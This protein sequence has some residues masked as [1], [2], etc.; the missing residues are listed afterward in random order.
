MEATSLPSHPRAL[1]PRSR[2]LL[3][4]L[5]DGRLV[6]QVRAGND[7]AFEVVYDRHH[8]GVL[9]FC[10]HMLG[11]QE[12]A[13]DA[14]QQTFISAYD[15]LRRTNRA[16][17][18]RPWLFTIARNRCLSVL[19][20]RRE[21]ATAEVELSTAGLA[22]DVERR[23]ELRELLADMAELP[24]EQRGA[25]VLSELGDLSHA[26]IAQVLG[27]EAAKVKSLVFQARS[28][29]IES[30]R[31]RETPCDEIRQQLATL[32]GGALRRGT[33][34][35]HVKACPGCSEYRDDVRRQRAMMAAVLPVIPSVGLRDGA[36]AAVGLG[37]GGSGGAAA[38]GGLGA[39]L[40]SGAA[41]VAVVAVVAGGTAGGLA[42]T[43]RVSLPVVGGSESAPA[44]EAPPGRA[45]AA[46][47]LV[48]GA[49][50]RSLKDHGERSRRGGEGKSDGRGFTPLRGGSSGDSAR[51]FALTRGQGKKLGLRKQHVRRRRSRPVVPP[52]R[53]PVTRAPRQ[54]SAPEPTMT[55][56]EAEPLA[57]KTLSPDAVKPAPHGRQ[58]P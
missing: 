13:E 54:E 26:D 47:G 34:R 18:L 46:Q 32:R 37:A 22:E 14:V 49:E 57:P 9:A 24:E 52:P 48:T 29:L 38:A 15:S 43:D 41:K 8:R 17:A 58:V 16:I 5:G 10:R 50:R 6:D 11:S 2:R 3:S 53:E 33:L 27:C 28:A 42:T 20:A 40:S 44:G 7:A 45:P 25:L 19:R 21:H 4:A 56:P 12:E 35:R 55:A 1:A 36:L 31:A 23:G 39:L 30:R 51:D